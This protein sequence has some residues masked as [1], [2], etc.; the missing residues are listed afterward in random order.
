MVEWRQISKR[1]KTGGINNAVNAKTKSLSNKGGTFVKTTVNDVEKRF[2]ERTIGGNKKV[3]LSQTNIALISIAGKSKKVKILDVLENE[4]NK[5][6][7]RQ[8]VI[9]KGCIIKVD[10]DGKEEKAKVTSRPG[11]F[12]QVSA[13]LVK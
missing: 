3:K 4:A 1:K 5:H 13:I 2:Q 11:Q 8:K 7:V 12:G 9:T 10:I 6:F